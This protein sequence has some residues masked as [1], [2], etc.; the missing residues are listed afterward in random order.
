MEMQDKTMNVQENL[1][2]K[3]VHQDSSEREVKA[4]ENGLSFDAFS[5]ASSSHNTRGK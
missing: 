2:S 4:L 1:I 3:V 5:C